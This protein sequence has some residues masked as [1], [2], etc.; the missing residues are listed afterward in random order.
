MKNGD[1]ESTYAIRDKVDIYLRLYHRCQYT[2]YAV[3]DG[4]WILDLRSSCKS[5]T[6][7]SAW[8]PTLYPVTESTPRIARYANTRLHLPRT[9]EMGI[10][11]SGS[12]GPAPHHGY[13]NHV[14]K[15][16]HRLGGHRSPHQRQSFRAFG[17]QG[18]SKPFR[19]VEDGCD[20][21]PSTSPTYCSSFS[22]HCHTSC[23]P[24]GGRASGASE[25]TG[26]RGIW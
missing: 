25:R 11:L 13:H 8:M 14:R 26:S 3:Q 12:E 10:S 24:K 1:P 16:H 2:S 7:I 6:G 20:V 17:Q 4:E 9:S 5:I 22:C 23:R 18:R 21:R 19:H 15:L